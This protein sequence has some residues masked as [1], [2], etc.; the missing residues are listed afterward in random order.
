LYRQRRLTG[1]TVVTFGGVGFGKGTTVTCVLPQ[2]GDHV[3]GQPV[4]ERRA[5]G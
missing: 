4:D 2:A 5:A 3:D 1:R